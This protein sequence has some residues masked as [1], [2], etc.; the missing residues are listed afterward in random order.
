MN[1]DSL[2]MYLNE[3]RNIPLLSADEEASLVKEAAGGNKAARNKLVESNLRFVVK[4]AKEYVNRG[5]EFEDLIDEGNAGLIQAVNHFDPNAGVKFISYAVWW[6]RQSIMKALYEFGHEIRL[7]MNRANELVNIEKARK[8]IGE[9][10]SEAAQAK[11]IADMLG[12]DEGIVRNL[13]SVSREMKSLDRNVRD[14]AGSETFGELIADDKYKTPEDETME[15]ALHEDMEEVLSNLS[16][17]EERILRLRYGFDGREP[18]SLK[19]VGDEIG[20]TKERIRQIEKHAL[21]TIRLPS[22][23]RK[24]SAY[25]A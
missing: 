9:N 10:K 21:S 16:P 8:L 2:S 17:K 22:R 15:N 20:L 12:M 11:E 18:M 3:I 6:I 1:Q 25:V 13:M 14:D 19:E 4:I 7:P 5:I 23:S 24:I